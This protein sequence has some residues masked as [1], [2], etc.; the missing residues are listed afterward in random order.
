MLPLLLATGVAILLTRPRGFVGVK[1][2][3]RPLIILHLQQDRF[4]R[5]RID[6][7]S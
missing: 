2:Q 6:Q 4:V 3:D 7:D 5:Q 1:S